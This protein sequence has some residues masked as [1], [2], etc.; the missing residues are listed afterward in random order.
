VYI[1][2]VV[3]RNG[4]VFVRCHVEETLSH[5][6]LEIPDWMLQESCGTTGI[7]ETPVVGCGA[8]RDLKALLDGASSH[9]PGLIDAQVLMQTLKCVVTAGII[10]ECE[11]VRPPTLCSKDDTLIRKSSSCAS[12]PPLVPEFQ[13]EF[14]R[15]SPN[16]V[17][18]RRSRGTHDDSALGSTLCSGVRE[19]WR[20]YAR[21][22]NGCWGCD[23]TYIKVKGRWIYLYRAVDKFG[24]TVDFLLSEHRDVA[25]AKRFFRKAIR[26]NGPPRVITLDG[27]AASHR[28]IRELKANG[29]VNSRVRV[30]CT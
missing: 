2:D 22:V 16:D 25:A 19:R 20:R 9:D 18:A 12:V 29:R 30:R 8:L 3:D 17:G 15:L 4:R 26:H 28:A 13:A 10:C 23:E 7:A 24:Q 27:Y 1:D 11:H 5:R 21:P 14:T 6:G